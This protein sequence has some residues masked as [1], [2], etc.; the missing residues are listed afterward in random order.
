[1]YNMRKSRAIRVGKSKPTLFDEET[2]NSSG[3]RW[4]LESEET[5]ENH[6]PLKYNILVGEINDIH[7]IKCNIL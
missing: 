6:I 3:I 5:I 7:Y 2:M 4:H 1:M